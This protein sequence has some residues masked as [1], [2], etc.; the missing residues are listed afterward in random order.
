MPRILAASVL[1]IKYLICVEA[2]GFKW[3]ETTYDE[4]NNDSLLIDS[5]CSQTKAPLFTK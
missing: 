4:L 3:S 2:L 1:V 5:A